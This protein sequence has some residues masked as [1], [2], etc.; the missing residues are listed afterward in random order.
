MSA[1]LRLAAENH[2][3][4]REIRDLERRVREQIYRATKAEHDAE[5]VHAAMGQMRRDCDLLALMSRDRRAAL[6]FIR[7]AHDIDS[8]ETA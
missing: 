5:Q 4:R 7:T 2:R 1:A 8:Q 3:L 6:E